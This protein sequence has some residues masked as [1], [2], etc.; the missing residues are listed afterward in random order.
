MPAEAEPSTNT[1]SGRTSLARAL[2]V[3]DVF[4]GDR[5]ELT[6]SAIATQSGLPLATAHRY[7][8]ELVRWGGID[9][10][11]RGTY[12]VGRKL[13]QIGTLAP[14][15]RRLRDVALPVLEDLFET[16]HKVVHLAVLDEDK[17][18]Y[19]EKLTPRH[20]PV[21]SQV[22]HRLPLHATGPGKVLLA[23][24]SAES[25][26]RI[27]S[28]PLPPMASGT[29]TDS[30]E[31]RNHLQNI[32]ETGFAI[33]RN[34]MTEGLASAAAPVFDSSGNAIAAISVVVPTRHQN[35][36]GLAQ[37]VRMAAAV[38]TRELRASVGTK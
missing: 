9:R 10:T 13:W 35:M 2:G 12:T 36:A 28:K 5:P 31:L 15:E 29:F 26:D 32:R 18:L 20:A 23:F 34:E 16:T 7:L 37:V 6:L 4:S 3:L 22:G 33:S 11:P 1:T 19:V 38:I 21:T 25:R 24:G 17:A 14:T 8:A 27:L 30:G